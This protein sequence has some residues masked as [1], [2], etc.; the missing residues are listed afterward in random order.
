M[1]LQRIR[2]A[3][4]PDGSDVG[5]DLE[6]R[7]ATA[8][9]RFVDALSCHEHWTS[10][11]GRRERADRAECAVECREPFASCVPLMA[12]RPTA[13]QANTPLGSRRGAARRRSAV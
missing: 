11:H 2:F 4:H 6:H 10:Q 3:V 9:L 1:P 7:H 13:V 12:Q 8:D 5:S